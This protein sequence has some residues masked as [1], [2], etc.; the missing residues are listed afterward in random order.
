MPQ[1]VLREAG[2]QQGTLLVVPEQGMQLQAATLDGVSQLDPQRAGIR[3]KGVLAFRV[4]QTPWNLALRI[5]QVDAWVQVTSLQHAT[6]NEAQVKVAANLQYQIENTGLQALRVFL[7]THA[8]SVRF[9]NEQVSDFLQVAGAVTNSL[10]LWEVKLQRRVLGPCLMQVTYQT[11]IP[12]QSPETLLR[13]VQAADV[14]LQRDCA[15]GRTPSSARGL[16]ARHVAA[17]R[18][19]EHSARVAAKPASGISEL[20]VSARRTGVSIAF[21]AGPPRSREAVAGA[22]QPDHADLGNCRRRRHA[23][24]GAA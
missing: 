15:G 14:N 11:L 23:H 2:K 7:Q 3:Q 9:Q 22:R 18:V 17:G 4:L 21:E 16:A 13:G 1:V 5:E 19:A 8:A 6:V 12:D 20:R 24:A 10:Q